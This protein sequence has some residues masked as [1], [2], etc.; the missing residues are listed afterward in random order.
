VLR[1]IQGGKVAR[2]RRWEARGRGVTSDFDLLEIVVEEPLS[3]SSATPADCPLP[4]Q[5]ASEESG[6]RLL[7]DLRIS[8]RGLISLTAELAPGIQSTLQV[9]QLRLFLQN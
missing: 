1:R 5:S 3:I 4:G 9:V 7:V 8:H 2:G 6:R